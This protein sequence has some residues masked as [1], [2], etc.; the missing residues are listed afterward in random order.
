MQYPSFPGGDLPP[1]ASP[2]PPP[3]VQMAARLMYLGCLLSVISLIIGIAS[4]HGLRATLAKADP[5]LTR[6]ELTAAVS[7]ARVEIVVVGLIG[8]ALW[9]WIAWKVRAGR[10]WARVTGTV[11]WVIDTLDLF[12]N[13]SRSA[14]GSLFLG[15]LVWLVG[16]AAVVFLWRRDA[17]AF[18]RPQLGR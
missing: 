10:N 18:F 1:A 13:L 3:S 7:A 2:G 14:G 16:L 4:F 6:S 8:A 5:K 17:T 9:L 11:F 15:L 12:V